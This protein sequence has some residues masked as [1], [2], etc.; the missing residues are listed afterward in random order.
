MSEQRPKTRTELA[1]ELGYS[2]VTLYKKI[3]KLK[4]EIPC[5]ENLSPKSQKM[6]KEALGFE[7]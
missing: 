6:I 7:I 4:L 1:K 2:R 3:Q 5:R